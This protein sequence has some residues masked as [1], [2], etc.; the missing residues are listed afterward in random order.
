MAGP[1]KRVTVNGCENLMPGMTVDFLYQGE[2]IE[3]FEDVKIVEIEYDVNEV[4]T[5]R[6]CPS[7]LI[8]SDSIMCLKGS[9]N[10]ELLGLKAI[11]DTNKSTLYGVKR[12]G[13]PV[14]NPIIMT[15]IGDLTEGKLQ[16][17]LDTIELRSG[18]SSNLILC[19]H[20][21]RRSIVSE[22][23]K[24]STRIANTELES[25]YKTV[26]YNGIPIVADRFCPDGEVYIL[27]TDHFVLHQLCD[28]EWLSG[29]D[30]S[31]LRQVPGKPVYTA[32]LVKYAELIC[33]RPNAQ[34]L[35]KDVIISYE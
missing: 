20:A 35:L 17:A 12:A 11:F 1:G 31:I 27:N 25:G 21:T 30:G 14:M 29:E 15:G 24:T 6:E 34:C 5:D 4:V 7:Y 18:S 2:I 23:A 28:W 9:G 22:L 33:N 3:G 13:N 8:Y 26:S 32:T 10:N 19:S 16:K